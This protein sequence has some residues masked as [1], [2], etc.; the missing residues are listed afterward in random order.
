MEAAVAQ[1]VSY[2]V[3]EVAQLFWDQ[4][5]ALSASRQKPAASISADRRVGT[6]TQQET[7][8]TATATG[9]PDQDKSPSTKPMC[10]CGVPAVLRTVKKR[11]PTHGRKY[12]CCGV[13]VG[14][15]RHRRGGQR[16]RGNDTA[17]DD[18]KEDCRFFVWKD[19]PR[20]PVRVLTGL[21]KWQ[22]QFRA[23]HL[24]LYSACELIKSRAAEG[25]SAYKRRGWRGRHS[26]RKRRRGGEG[27]KAHDN[28]N[29]LG[30]D[31]DDGSDRSDEE[32]TKPTWCVVGA[33]T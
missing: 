23:K 13:A 6:S 32:G 12:Y 22:A 29:E 4:A 10:K 11:G 21:G 3:R 15:F 28:N 17:E 27:R 20:K 5:T 16:R 33:G 19:G 14:S 7:L 2:R 9:D 18:G 24:A 1:E 8:S 26:W 30:T 31:D 25:D